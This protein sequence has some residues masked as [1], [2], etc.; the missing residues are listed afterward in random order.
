MNK[1]AILL[2]TLAVGVPSPAASQVPVEKIAYYTCVYILTDA[3]FLNCSG[4]VAN[5]DGTG[6]VTLSYGYDGIDPAWSPDGSRI[7][8]SDRYFGLSVWSPDIGTIQLNA[9]PGAWSPT[10]APDG[11]HIAFYST[12]TGSAELFAWHADGPVTQLT[13]QAGVIGAPA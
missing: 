1:P 5:L 2:I 9:G 13:H 11:Q 6:V 4:T 7:A 10:W 8:F 3:W 12:R